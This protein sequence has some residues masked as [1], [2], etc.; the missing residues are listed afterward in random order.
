M[1]TR[2]RRQLRIFVRRDT[3]G[4]YVSVLVFLPRDRYNTTVRERFSEIL[5]EQLRR[6]VGRVHRPD[7]RVDD[8]A[9]ALRGPPAEGRGASPTSTSPTSSAGSPTPRA[10]GATTS[11]RP[12]SPSSAR[13][14]A[15][16]SPAASRRRSPRPTRRTSPRPPARSTS[17]GSRRSARPAPT[18]RCSP[19]L[20]AARGE[21]R[22]KVFR[23]GAPI[24]LSRGAAGAVVDGR[25]GRRRAALPA[26]PRRPPVVHLRVRAALRARHA[27]P[28]ARA[29]PGHDPRGLGRLQRDR[30][31]QRA[32]PR[33]RPDLAPGDRA[34]RV[35]QVHEAGQQPV[36][37][38]LHRGGA[39]RQHRHH[40]AARAALRG[41]LRPGPQR[42][43]R[44]R[45]GAYGAGRGDRHP[46][47][48]GARRRRQPRPRP[49]PALLPDPHPG[50]AAHQLLPA[51][52][53]RQAPRLHVVQARAVG[54]PR[55]ARSRGRASRSS[56]T[57]RGSRACTCASARSRAAACAGPTAATTSAPRCSAWSRRR[58]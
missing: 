44:R 42:P 32:R 52:R 5:K 35:R 9:R 34:A 53:R 39:A 6:R 15:R 3:Y 51:R 25:R 31:L 29:V 43:R 23:R 56:S 45:R 50:H 55:P 13:T 12:P 27:R 10:R 1:E 22:L 20:D 37:R 19:P 47:P 26:R 24:S 54:D 21:A 16:G 58:W 18:C 17:A 41:A 2:G 46:D 36:R 38:R 7:E 14:S 33:R 49:D 28:H 11:P 8:R 57:R 4:R 48:A 30:R 40:P